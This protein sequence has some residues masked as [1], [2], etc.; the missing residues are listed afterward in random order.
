MTAPIATIF[1]SK[2]ADREWTI[3]LDEIQNACLST[4]CTAIE[5]AS[6]PDEIEYLGG[7]RR[8][9]KRDTYVIR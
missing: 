1:S 7:E 3:A 4:F 5:T 9:T 6:G 2:L 8:D